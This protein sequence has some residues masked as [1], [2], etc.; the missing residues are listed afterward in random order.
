MLSLEVE[1]RREV[2]EWREDK[3]FKEIEERLVK[4]IIMRV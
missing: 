4:M 2:I 3:S 1:E